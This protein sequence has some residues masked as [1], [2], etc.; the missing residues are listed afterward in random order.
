MTKEWKQCLRIGPSNSSQLLAN[1]V[2]C[3]STRQ[4]IKQDYKLPVFVANVGRLHFC[5]RPLSLCIFTPASAPT[6][7]PPVTKTL[8]AN[9]Y[10]ANLRQREND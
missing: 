10:F 3:I 7:F 8:Y 6:P 4:V 5:N 9:H 2:C 1:V